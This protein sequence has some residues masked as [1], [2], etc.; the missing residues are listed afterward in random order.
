MAGADLVSIFWDY[1]SST[2]CW[3]VDMP[4]NVLV[5]KIRTI[6]H[7]YGRVTAFKAYFDLAEAVSSKSP[8][9]RSELQA[10]ARLLNVDVVDMLAFAIDHPAPATVILISGDRDFA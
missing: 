8:N 4:G 7:Q 1:G 10:S 2:L 3:S 5:D 9:I 6:A